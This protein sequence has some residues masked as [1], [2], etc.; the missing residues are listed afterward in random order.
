MSDL[1]RGGQCLTFRYIS[2]S[3]PLQTLLSSFRTNFCR[4]NSTSALQVISLFTTLRPLP[5]M[6]TYQGVPP[7]NQE[8]QSSSYRSS[9][10]TIIPNSQEYVQHIPATAVMVPPT[11]S[12]SSS[13]NTQAVNIRSDRSSKLFLCTACLGLVLTLESSKWS[14]RILRRAP[15]VDAHKPFSYESIAVYI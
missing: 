5:I 15:Q 8:A 4:S 10:T 7:S 2:Q 13:D 11:N 12:N 9:P 3:F 14:T 1:T 6:S